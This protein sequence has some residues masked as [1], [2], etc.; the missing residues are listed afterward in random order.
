MLKAEI[1]ITLKKTV[2]DPQGLTI[3]HALDSLGYKEV[4]EVRIGKLVTVRLNINDKKEAEQRLNEMCK[5]LLANPIIE[6]YSSKI[7]E[8]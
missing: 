6:D 4:E 2:A 1:Y 5:K 3:K 8:V 7:E